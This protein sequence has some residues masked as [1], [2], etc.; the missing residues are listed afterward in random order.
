MLY[1]KIKTEIES[2]LTNF[3][4]ISKNRKIEL[5]S[6]TQYINNKRKTNESVDLIV[7]CTHNSRRSHIGQLWLA[8]GATYYGLDNFNT[9]SGGTE[10]TAFHPNAI[11]TMKK[12]GFD[13]TTTDSTVTNPNYSIKWSEEQVPYDAFSTRFDDSPNPTKNFGA[14]MVCTEADQGCPFVPG[15]DFRIAL[16]FDDPKAFD[17]TSQQTEKYTERAKQ[18]GTEMMYVLSK[19]K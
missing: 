15:T 5:D 9:F 7:I 4:S 14:I 16:P 12:L 1:S 8:A 6:L 11:E 13:I 19:V 3:D 10:A 2:F 17:N 18:I